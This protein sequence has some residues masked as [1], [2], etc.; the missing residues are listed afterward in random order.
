MRVGVRCSGVWQGVV[1]RI[2]GVL[3][4]A[5]SP[6][7]VHAVTDGD[8]CRVRRGQVGVVVKSDL[9]ARSGFH[10]TVGLVS[11][12]WDH[13]ATHAYACGGRWVVELVWWR[14]MRCSTG[15]GVVGASGSQ[16]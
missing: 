8:P 2:V 7:F 16:A 14:A 13:G 9:G 5:R 1:E 4:L 15:H 10:T 11:V 12:R 3:V 6:W